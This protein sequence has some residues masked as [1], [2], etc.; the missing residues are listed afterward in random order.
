METVSPNDFRGGMTIEVDGEVYTIIEFQHVKPGKGGAFVRTKLKNIDNGAMITK[1]FRA[2][3]KIAKA[4]VDERKMQFLYRSGTQY[5]FI[6]NE[7]FEQI[8]VSEEVLGDAKKYIREN[9]DVTLLLYEGKIIGVDLPFFVELK[10]SHT[11]AGVKGDT[12]SGGTKP[13]VLETGLAIRVPFF[14]STGDTIKVDTR[15]GEYIERV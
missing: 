8:E 5:H 11:D 10:V 12:V 3:E 6:D 9:S 2:E 4:R 7:T 15:T 14:V 13:A 1:T